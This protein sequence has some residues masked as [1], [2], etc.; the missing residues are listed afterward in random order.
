VVGVLSVL[1]PA[2]AAPLAP[3]GSAA[4]DGIPAAV[5]GNANVTHAPLTV[6]VDKTVNYTL[7]DS[8]GNTQATGTVQEMV[9]KGDTSNG[10][11][12]NQLDFMFQIHSTTGTISQAT[13]T[14]YR[15]FTVD[16]SMVTG[17]TQNANLPLSD[18]FA[19]TTVGG[20]PVGNITRSGLGDNVSFGFSDANFGPGTTS[21][22][23][24]IRTNATTFDALGTFGLVDGGSGNV[25]AWEPTPEPASLLLLSIGALGM[26]GYA[27]RKRRLAA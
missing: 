7:K 18:Q 12:A 3:G 23:M 10:Q 27:W 9:V 4:N 11:S 13:A 26:G 19:A 22:V 6:V 16:A 14:V 8:G 2:V 15:N 5:D 24:L 20:V 1:N 21:V 17:A 25:A